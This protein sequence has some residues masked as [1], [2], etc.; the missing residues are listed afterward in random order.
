MSAAACDIDGDG[1]DEL[2]VGAPHYAANEKAFNTGRV[3]LFKKTG[4]K[5]E[6]LR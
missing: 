6:E 1:Y 4:G 3:H 2:V 5:L